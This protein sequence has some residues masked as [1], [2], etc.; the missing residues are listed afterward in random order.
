LLLAATLS[1]AQTMASPLPTWPAATRI[2]RVRIA[3]APADA[4]AV[5]R[6]SGFTLADLLYTPKRV[7]GRDDVATGSYLLRPELQLGQ[8]SRWASVLLRLERRSTADRQFEGFTL[9]RDEWVEEA[10]WRAKPDDRWLAEVGLRLDQGTSHQSAGTFVAP[11][12]KLTG[13]SATG[14]I[15]YLPS[16][17]WRIGVLGSLDRVDVPDDGL[18]ASRVG[19]V[20]PHAVWQKGGAYRVE[21]IVRRAAITGGAVP[22]L[23][24]SGFPI[25]PDRWDYSVQA[26][27]RVRERANLVLSSDGRAPLGRSWIHN[28][29][30]E[31]RAY[32]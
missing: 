9:T 27:L 10:R 18:V 31:L 8:R 1:A 32:F 28:G 2:A 17:A 30:A 26:S 11:E 19:R 15:T 13:Q 12:R 25:L 14:E 16:D 29:R 22:A 5:A 4:E 3:G 21:A 23:V 24:P 7:L 6:R 20:G